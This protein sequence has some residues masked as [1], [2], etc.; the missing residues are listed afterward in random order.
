MIKEKYESRKKITFMPKKGIIISKF[1][2]YIKKLRI[3][4]F[5]LNYQLIQDKDWP[6]N[7]NQKLYQNCT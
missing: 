7:K 3:F 5:L 2:A 6:F 1:F 4:D